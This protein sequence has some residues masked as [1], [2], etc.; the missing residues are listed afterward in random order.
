MLESAPTDSA[1][2]IHFCATPAQS[3]KFVILVLLMRFSANC[4]WCSVEVLGTE[5]CCISNGYQLITN[6]TFHRS[7]KLFNHTKSVL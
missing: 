4:V 1:S 6:K 5:Y 7:L 3:L 2:T